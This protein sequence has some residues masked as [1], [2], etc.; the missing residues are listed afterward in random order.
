MQH[1][2]CIYLPA[3]VNAVYIGIIHHMQHYACICLQTLMPSS[4]TW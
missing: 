2:A 4:P 3:D 1:Y